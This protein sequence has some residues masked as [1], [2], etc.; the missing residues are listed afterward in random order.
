MEEKKKKAISAHAQ[1]GT[2]TPATAMEPQGLLKLPAELLDRIY[3]Y[4]D[5]DASVDLEPTQPNVVS[6][7]LTCKRLRETALPTL[8]RHVIL[9]LRWRNDVLLE[10]SLFRLR[11]DHAHLARH[12]RTVMI[13]VQYEQLS[14]PVSLPSSHDALEKAWAKYQ[15]AFDASS[16]HRPF[17]TGGSVADWL[18]PSC[19]PNQHLPDSSIEDWRDHALN[20]YSTLK[21]QLETAGGSIADLAWLAEHQAAERQVAYEN[22]RRRKEQHAADIRKHENDIRTFRET[23][24]Y[25]LDSDEDQGQDG[26]PPPRDPKMWTARSRAKLQLDAFALALNCIPPSTR[27]LILK[28]VPLHPAVNASQNFALSTTAAAIRLLGPNLATMS[29]LTREVT[30]YDMPESILSRIEARRPQWGETMHVTPEVLS[31][32]KCLKTLRLSGA[33]QD[34]GF[35]RTSKD[36]SKSQYWSTVSPALETLELWHIDA[37]EA[38]LLS[39]LRAFAGVRHVRLHYMKLSS[40]HAPRP[41]NMS[42]ECAQG[43]SLLQFAVSFRR[44]MPNSSLHLHDVNHFHKA[45]VPAAAVRFISAAVCMVGSTVDDDRVQRLMQDFESFYSSWQSQ[46]AEVIDKVV[47][48]K[49]F[50]KLVDEAMSSRF[51]A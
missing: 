19:V 44:A 34:H 5:W 26:C 45:H 32:L 11:R 3:T 24:Q 17:I 48:N 39:F 33:A 47:Q 9:H 16:Q 30:T 23:G 46:E 1:L 25:P 27:S 28:A 14:K 51:R 15:R 8:F 49:E 42:W 37:D 22:Q 40:A 29:I 41:A 18:N 38:K 10:P 4:L 43:V 21:D 6:L 50:G 35:K 13:E 36:L 7:S 12:V 2:S 31:Q 20:Q